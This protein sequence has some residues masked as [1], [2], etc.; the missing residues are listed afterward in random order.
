MR[1]EIEAL[2]GYMKQTTTS[3]AFRGRVANAGTFGLVSYEKGVVALTALAIEILK[4]DQEKASR[5]EAFLHVPL[6]KLMYDEF[7]NGML[8]PPSAVERAMAKFGVA[9]KQTEKARQAF[10]RS[11]RQAGFFAHGDDRLVKPQLGSSPGSSA[12]P[13]T[14]TPTASLPTVANE[15][16]HIGGGGG[17]PPR[18]P[19]PIIAGLIDRLPPPDSVWE[20]AERAKWLQTMTSA[21]DLIYTAGNGGDIRV[22]FRVLSNSE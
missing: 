13:G 5:V 2:A 8:P 19:D 6:Y 16:R 10:T 17:A 3:G 1:S 11:A 9:S 14:G 22:E 21:F 15:A 20:I 18:G 4:P 7:K 12:I